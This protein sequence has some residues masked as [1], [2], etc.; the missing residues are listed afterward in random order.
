M[1]SQYMTY[2]VKTWLSIQNMFFEK[3]MFKVFVVIL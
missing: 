1:F 3:N 2:Y